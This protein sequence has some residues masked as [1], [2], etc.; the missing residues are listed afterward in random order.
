MKPTTK[1]TMAGLAYPVAHISCVAKLLLLFSS[2][3]KADKH[4]GSVRTLYF[5]RLAFQA[6]LFSQMSWKHAANVRQGR[7]H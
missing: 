4:C 6:N 2:S 1:V 5:K 7:W 3:R